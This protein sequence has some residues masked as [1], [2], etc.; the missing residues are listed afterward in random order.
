MH[1]IPVCTLDDILPGTGVCALAR[2]EHVAIF[3][4]GDRTYAVSN[5]DPFTKASVLSRGLTGSY[6]DRLKVVS[7]LLK[8]AFDLETG[9]SLDDPT[10]SLATYPT[11][12]EDG[13]VLL[14][15]PVTHVAGTPERSLTGAVL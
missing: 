2:G 7:P 11:R 10:V 13:R 4:V 12:V 14:G 5:R 3:R 6:G 8:H 1:W 9:A 15:L